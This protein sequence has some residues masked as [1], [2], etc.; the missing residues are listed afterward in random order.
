MYK[1]L[2]KIPTKGM[3]REAWL[4]ERRKSI[5]GSDCASIL[6]MNEYCSPYTLWCEKRGM[7]PEKEDNEAMRIGRDLEDYVAKR[8]TENTG[9]KVRKENSLI[10][11][12]E[13]PYLHA[14]VDRVIVGEN[15]VLECKT[16][17]A[18]NLK[19]YKNGDYPDRFYVQCCEYML[20]CGFDKAYLAV[21]VLGKG[22]YVF[23][24]NRDDDELKALN[25]SCR[26]FW[27]LVE[28]NT[29]PAIDGSESTGDTILHLYPN[30]DGSK[31]DLFGFEP[32]LEL[33]MALGKQI[34]ELKEMQD[35]QANVIKAYMQEAE[36]GESSN[37]KVTLKT[38]TRKTF[39]TKAYI[40]DHGEG[41]L[42][43]YYK[44][45]ISRPFKVTKKGA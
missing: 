3:S 16:V 5:G 28:S 39:D 42:D 13:Y 18:L 24:I 14:N 22:F 31:T 2:I 34:K 45:S 20:V 29:P 12:P 7:L 44:E 15:A 8:F 1:N 4:E 26:N 21:L 35:E 27:N 33:Y 19:Q 32:N 10:R 41:S 38:Q 25:D 30:S 17:S 11:N 43:G 9:K 37:F 40:K 6:G 23:E 36:I